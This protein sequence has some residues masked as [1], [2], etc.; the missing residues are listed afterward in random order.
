[1]TDAEPPSPATG[2]GDEVSQSWHPERYER[3][4]RFVSDH[5]IGLVDELLRP[6]PGERILDLAAATAS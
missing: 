3:H 4:A 6:R 1:M 5:G 2:P